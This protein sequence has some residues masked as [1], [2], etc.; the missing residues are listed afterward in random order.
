MSLPTVSVIVPTYN[1]ADLLPRALDSILGQTYEGPIEVIVIDDGSTDHTAAIMDRYLAGNSA[2]RVRFEQPGRGGVVAARN[3]GVSIATGTWIAFLDSDDEWLPGKLAAQIALAEATGAGVVHTGFRYIDT[4]GQFT[5]DGPQR[6]D[7]PARGKCVTAM[8]AED[9]VIF[10]SVAIRRDVL[11]R[12]I[13]EAPHG[14]AFDPRWTCGEDYDLLLRA[15]VVT[16]FAYIPDVLTY[17]RVHA[18]QTGMDNLPRVFGYHCRVQIDFAD[19]FGKY[20]GLA[21]DAGRRAA[22]E[23]LLGRVES[24]YW[25]RELT[26]ARQLCTLATELGLADERINALHRRCRRP[27]SLLKIKDWIESGR[28][29]ILSP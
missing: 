24:L 19:R 12:I 25:Q 28:S 16:E 6:V 13:S 27:K 11:D 8:L 20:L 21:D 17:Y 9:T 4:T 14:K 22:R 2:V 1:R 15:A 18:N 3:H 29:R 7:N 26:V 23:F 5:D 10:S